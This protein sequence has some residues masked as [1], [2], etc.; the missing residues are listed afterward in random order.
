VKNIK[1]RSFKMD[2]YFF[3]EILMSVLKTLFKDFIIIFM[4]NYAYNVS[5]VKVLN[6]FN[7]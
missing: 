2:E 7:E 3:L 1:R 5:E 6:F 4:K